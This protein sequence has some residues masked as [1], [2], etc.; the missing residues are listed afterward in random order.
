MC[1]GV[2]VERQKVQENESLS[3]DS[4][5]THNPMRVRAAGSALNPPPRAARR[6]PTVCPIV[7]E[8][9]ETAGGT[10]QPYEEARGTE[11][12]DRHSGEEAQNAARVGR[13]GAEGRDDR[14]W[15]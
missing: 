4:S 1:A 7:L 8:P 15:R 13:R 12:R 5:V 14:E 11:P 6:A 3:S 2:G 9:F 10:S